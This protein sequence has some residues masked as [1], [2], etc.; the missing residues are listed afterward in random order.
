MSC[1]KNVLPPPLFQIAIAL[2]MKCNNM[3]LGCSLWNILT[4][5]AQQATND[6]WQTQILTSIIMIQSVYCY[7]WLILILISINNGK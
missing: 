6:C 5:F 2:I 4:Q 1:F 7:E 3:F